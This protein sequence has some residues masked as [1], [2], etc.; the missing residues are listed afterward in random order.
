MRSVLSAGGSLDQIIAAGEK[1]LHLLR[2]A[3]LNLPP[4]ALTTRTLLP[5]LTSLKLNDPY[6][7]LKEEE[8]RIGLRIYPKLKELVREAED[9]LRMAGLIAATGNIIDIGAQQFYDIEKS[10][11][12]IGKKGFKIDN[13]DLFRKKLATPQQ[14]LYILDNTG[15]LFFDR[16]L[17]EE[18]SG[19]EV[20]GVVKERPIHND[21]TLKEARRA[22]IDRLITTGDG[23]LGIDWEKSGR[24]FL[25]AYESADIV[26]GKGHANFESLVDGRRDAFLILKAKCPVVAEKLGVEVGDLVFYYYQP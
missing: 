19:H 26:I 15:E 4:N 18:L 25:T 9:R 11:E 17:I 10:V 22:G 12:E 21:A 8:L 23:S 6:Q 24:E 14:I 3:D 5:I 2:H 7:Q 1:A 16:V 20:I 13:F